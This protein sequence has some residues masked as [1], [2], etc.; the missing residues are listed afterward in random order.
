MVVASGDDAKHFPPLLGD[1]IAAGS[2]H[3]LQDSRSAKGSLKET[4]PLW[5]EI[6]GNM[7]A[8]QPAYERADH[9]CVLHPGQAN[10][11]PIG[12]HA[13]P[14]VGRRQ[15]MFPQY[16]PGDAGLP[17]RQAGQRRHGA[18]REAR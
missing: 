17:C 13:R 4:P 5:R 6:T 11:H 12:R 9:L 3:T 2:T 10:I 8:S 18:W 14:P 7:L 16:C 1:E 15:T